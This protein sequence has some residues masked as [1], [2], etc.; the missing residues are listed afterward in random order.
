MKRVT[1]IQLFSTREGTRG[2]A[3]LAH[4]LPI[5]TFEHELA[6]VR[7]VRGR[8]V[9]DNGRYF[10]VSFRRFRGATLG[11]QWRFYKELD[12]ERYHLGGAEISEFR[13]HSIKE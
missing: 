6:F 13:Y 8:A 3:N 5:F 1:T 11:W 9:K 2:F 10:S 7:D 4:V 12:P